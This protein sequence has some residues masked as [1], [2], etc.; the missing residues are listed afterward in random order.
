MLPLL[1]I[2]APL[3]CLPKGK[4]AFVIASVGSLVILILILLPFYL[5]GWILMV[6]ARGGDPETQIELAR[7]HE[8]HCGAIQEWLL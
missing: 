5:P 4:K 2:A 1:P 3:L 8:N 6:K 7:W